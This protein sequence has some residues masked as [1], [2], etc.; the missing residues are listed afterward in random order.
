MDLAVSIQK[1]PFRLDARTALRAA[2]RFWFLVVVVGQVMFASAVAAFYGR[3]AGRGDFDAWNRVMTHGYVPGEP[4]G[5][6]AVGIH[7]A[8][9]VIIILAGALQLLPRIRIRAPAFHRWNGRLYLVAAFA[10]S[11]AGLYMMWF[12]GAV[13]DL[14][15]HLGQSLDGVLIML[16]ASMA[17]RHALARNFR[18][19]GRWAMRLYLVVSASLFI[20]A[21][22]LLS[23][24]F[25]IDTSTAI[26]PFFTIM[27]FAQYLV[28]LGILELYWRARDGATASG[29]IA[30]AAALSVLTMLLG[31]GI[32]GATIGLFLPDIELAYANRNS[33]A[34][35]LAAT[36]AQGG[37]DQAV[38]QYRQIK[39]ASPGAYNFA[40]EELNKLGYKL[41]AA[42][43][44]GP[45]IRILQLN[46][47]AYPRSGNAYD[48]LAEAYMDDGD[49]LRAIADYEKSLTL[50]PSNS[51]AVRMLRKLAAP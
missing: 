7:L 8:S 28:P 30:M 31:I 51:N 13:G 10:V 44:F 22:L 11:L 26:G 19:H 50:L 41:L 24:P 36:L 5:N 29:R 9:A 18:V 6:V 14:S 48:S 33:I 47:E 43:K 15:Q 27:S 49:R 23:V 46:V 42:R 45:A 20:R 32:A 39:A 3:A 35:P 38:R 12:R 25:G 21:G 2:A 4:V 40:E 34:E 17:L 37:A 16:C 1:P